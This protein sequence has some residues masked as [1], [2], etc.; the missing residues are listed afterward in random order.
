MAS[1]FALMAAIWASLLVIVHGGNAHGHP[2]FVQV[3][4][5]SLSG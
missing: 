4:G 2:F 3:I 1:P 5:S